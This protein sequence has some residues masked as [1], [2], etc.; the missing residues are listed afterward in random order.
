M[1]LVFIWDYFGATLEKK[2]K[3]TKK[4]KKKTK[5]KMKM[6]SVE[7]FSVGVF[8]GG[9]GSESSWE[10]DHAILRGVRRPRIHHA[11]TLG[12]SVG[13]RDANHLGRCTTYLGFAHRPRIHRARTLG[14]SVGARDANHLGR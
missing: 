7:G 10:I 4:K 12:F 13:T 14:Y 1:T 11:R 8:R 5:K 6:K 2:K 9:Q 3:K